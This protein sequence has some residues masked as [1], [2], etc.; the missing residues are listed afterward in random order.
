M[1]NGFSKI[2]WDSKTGLISD[3]D[4]NNLLYTTGNTLATVEPGSPYSIQIVEEGESFPEEKSPEM[5]FTYDY[6]YY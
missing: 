6:L 2:N 3:F 1:P 5:T 4:N